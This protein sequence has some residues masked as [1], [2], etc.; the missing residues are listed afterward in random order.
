MSR[1]GPLWQAAEFVQMVQRFRSPHCQHLFP[2]GSG[3]VLTNRNETATGALRATIA[4][5]KTAGVPLPSLHLANSAAHCSIFLQVR[6]GLAIYG[7]Y[8][9][10]HFNR[11][12][13]SNPPYKSKRG[14]LMWDNSPLNCHQFIAEQELRLAVVG[15]GWWVPRNL[16]NKMTV[17]VRGKR[18]PQIGAISMDQ[19]MLD[20]KC[21]PRCTRRGSCHWAGRKGTNLSW[22]LGSWIKYYFLGNSLRLQAPSAHVAVGQWTEQWEREKTTH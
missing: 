20:V 18:V 19:L 6:V 15:I 22:R 7:L 1:L 12:L 21:H 14:L 11:W 13:I 9:A 5:I 3:R 4:Q 16:S 8:P 10:A 2:P 17:L